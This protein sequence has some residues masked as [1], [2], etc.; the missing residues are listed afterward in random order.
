MC[1]YSTKLVAW[2]DRELQPQQMIELEQHLHECGECRADLAK[3][4]GT[5]QILGEYCK[6][7]MTAEAEQGQRRWIPTL[8]AAAAI[9]VVAA[10]TAVLWRTR[11]QPLPASP[12]AAASQTAIVQP[13][14]SSVVPEVA[15]PAAN[16][17]RRHRA[18]PK[19]VRSQVGNGLAP[20]PQPVVEVA[21]PADSMFPPGAVPEGVNFLADVNFAPDGS[22]RQ[23]RLRPRLTAIERSTPQP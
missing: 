21:I 11:V 12:A 14:Q 15:G 7:V 23:M 6:A 2:L 19:P 9:L 20:A 16:A 8:L 3:Y 4:E 18:R 10:T 5:S 13:A 22:A 17:M 1:K